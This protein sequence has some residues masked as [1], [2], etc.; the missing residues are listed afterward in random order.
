MN[1]HS[2]LSAGAKKESVAFISS[3]VDWEWFVTLTF[4]HDVG[5][6]KAHELF[7]AFCRRLAQKTHG[8]VHVAWVWNFQTR[9]VLHFHA[10]FKSKVKGATLSNV[11]IESNG[12]PGDIRVEKPRDLEAVSGYL[13]NH[14]HWEINVACPRWA[15]C[16]RNHCIVANC[17]WPSIEE[18]TLAT[19]H[20]DS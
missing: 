6:R 4:R 15:P 12:W 3:S 5:P 8:H 13:M 18:L 7:K 14:N 10:L 19:K 16:K 2:A 11:A 17:P 1:A 20:V 9:G